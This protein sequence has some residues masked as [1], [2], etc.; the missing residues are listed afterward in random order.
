MR[1][2]PFRP[3]A[4]W[5]LLTTKHKKCR[6]FTKI[7]NTYAPQ[8]VFPVKIMHLPKKYVENWEGRKGKTTTM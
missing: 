5:F 4:S 8:F 3:L 1:S 7:V 2:D 6:I